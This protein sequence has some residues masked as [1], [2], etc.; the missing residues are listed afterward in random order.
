MSDIRIYLKNSTRQIKASK[1][2]GMYLLAC[3]LENGEEVTCPTPPIVFK[4]SAAWLQTEAMLLTEALRRVKK[5]CT[6]E[7]YSE[8]TQLDTLLHKWIPSWEEKDWKKS[9]GEDVPEI[10]RDLAELARTHE[11]NVTNERHEYSSWMET[12][13]KGEEACLKDLESLILMRRSTGQQKA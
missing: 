11:I 3:K 6:I 8:N 9:D 1:R 10:Y 12:Q 13:L 2:R 4:A 7:L 5:P